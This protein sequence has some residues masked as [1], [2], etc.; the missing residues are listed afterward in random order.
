ML[1]RM[2]EALL[3]RMLFASSAEG[4]PD[5][6][7]PWCPL[8]LTVSGGPQFDLHDL[9]PHSYPLRVKMLNRRQSRQEEEFE[10]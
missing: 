1:L 7:G 2:L 10:R 3:A 9:I 8:R 5:L 4:K 6:S